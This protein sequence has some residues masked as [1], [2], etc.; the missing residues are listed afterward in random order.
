LFNPNKKQFKK[1]EKTKT[2]DLTEYIL[3][4]NL[5]NFILKIVKISYALIKIN[6]IEINKKIIKIYHHQSNFESNF[7]KNL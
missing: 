4:Y 3:N 1:K 6:K 2:K 5:I 7:N